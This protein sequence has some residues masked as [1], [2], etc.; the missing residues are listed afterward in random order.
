MAPS[1]ISRENEL[2]LVESY[3]TPHEA[4]MARSALQSIGIHAV[5]ADEHVI[6]AN[7]FLVNA[8]R[9]VNLLV[10]ARD[11]TRAH[12][13]L[14]KAREPSPAEARRAAERKPC[15][16][17]GSTDTAPGPPGVRIALISWL[18]DGK[19]L[20]QRGRRTRCHNCGELF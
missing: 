2:Q 12:E 18:R 3:R 8:I 19:A 6:G 15:R 14:I 20:F 11:L 1:R 10:A 13:F 7:P 16:R 4:H 9:G 17:C 5:I